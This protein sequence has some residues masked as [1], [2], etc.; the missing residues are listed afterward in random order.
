MKVLL[1]IVLLVAIGVGVYLKYPSHTKPANGV[2]IGASVEEVEKVL[3]K[4]IR[5]LPSFGRENRIYQA[6][7]GT[8][9]M[10]I[11][12]GGQLIEIH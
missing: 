8:R 6:Q 5:V 10:L 1:G 4:P 11:F 2:R 3:G 9:Y 12:E 7:S